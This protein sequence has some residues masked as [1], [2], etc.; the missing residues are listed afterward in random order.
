MTDCLVILYPA[1]R[2]SVIAMFF[3]CLWWARFF[4]TC[5]PGLVYLGPK[6]EMLVFYQF[7]GNLHL[8]KAK[9]ELAGDY[10]LQVM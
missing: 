2:Q 3:L 7:R 9:S 5:S 10:I 1:W 6:N 8:L 4:A